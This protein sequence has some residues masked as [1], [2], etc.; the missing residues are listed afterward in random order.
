V[1]NFSSY[2]KVK[3]LVEVDDHIY[4]VFI[5]QSSQIK[6]LFIAKNSNINNSQIQSIFNK[7]N[8]TTTNKKVKESQSISEYDRDDNGGGLLGNLLWDVSEYD[9]LRILKIYEKDKTVIVLI[10]SNIQLHKSVDNILAY[11]F[12]VDDEIPKSLF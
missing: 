12:E 3:H 9:N 4:A 8:L 1:D 7:L 2:D 10:K 11:Y 6:D 5:V